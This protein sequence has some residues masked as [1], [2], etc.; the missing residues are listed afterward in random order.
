M[1]KLSDILLKSIVVSHHNTDR[2]VMRWESKISK[3]ENGY[4]VEYDDEIEDNR[5]IN[6]KEVFE[7]NETYNDEEHRKE[8]LEAFIKVVWWLLEHFGLFYSKWSKY[9]LVMNIEKG[10]NV[11]DEENAENAEEDSE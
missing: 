11:A 3:V 4:I 6:K 10:S 7:I 1:S 8:D 2:L 5:F 9:N